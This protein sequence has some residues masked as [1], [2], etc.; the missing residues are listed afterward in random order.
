LFN[1]NHVLLNTGLLNESEQ[2]NIENLYET[3]VKPIGADDTEEDKDHEMRPPSPNGNTKL[4]KLYNS[5]IGFQKGGIVNIS[6]PFKEGEYKDP[7]LAS[8]F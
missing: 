8:P 3:E 1:D 6:S 7:N 5:K 2:G 4:T